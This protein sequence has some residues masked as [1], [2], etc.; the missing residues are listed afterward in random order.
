[1]S[2]QGAIHLYATHVCCLCIFWIRVRLLW[3]LEIA[4]DCSRHNGWNHPIRIHLTFRQTQLVEMVTWQVQHVKK[5]RFRFTCSSHSAS[6]KL[7]AACQHWKHN[8]TCVTANWD[9]HAIQT[10]HCDQ[11]SQS[12]SAGGKI[13]SGVYILSQGK[14]ECIFCLTKWL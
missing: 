5:Q 14:Q 13:A 1:M 9:S 8:I 12:C 10:C 2:T 4:M 3:V 11:L 7:L 6:E